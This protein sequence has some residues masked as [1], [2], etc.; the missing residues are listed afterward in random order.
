M[1]Y[2][3]AEI[4]KQFWVTSLRKAVL[5]NVSEEYLVLGLMVGFI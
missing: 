5:C 1:K 4:G 2:A 3:T